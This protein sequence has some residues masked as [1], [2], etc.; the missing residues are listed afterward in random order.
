MARRL[1]LSLILICIVSFGGLALIFAA[2]AHP[3]LGLDL[4]GGISVTLEPKAGTQ[5]DRAG[6]DLA[7][8]RIRER[9]DSL[10]VAEPEILRQG[11]AIVINLPGVENQDK[12]LQLVQVTGKVNL[13]PVLRCSAPTVTPDSTTGS[14]TESTTVGETT[15]PGSSTPA[16]TVRDSATTVPAAATTATSVPASAGFR[17][18][19]GTG[20]TT[21]PPTTDAATDS[22]DTPPTTAVGAPEESTVPTDSTGP[23]EAPTTTVAIS[24]PNV[25]Q[26]LP[27]RDGGG[28]LVGASGG[29]GEVFESDA[30]ASI[31]PGSGWGVTVTLKSGA[32]GEGVWN[33]L[34][35]QCNGGAQTCPSGQLAIELDGDIIS[36][37][38]MNQSS[39]TGGVQIS[40]SFAESEAKNLA[41]VLRS[42]ALPVELTTQTVQNV[43]PT[44]GSDSLRAAI[45]SGLVGVALVLLFMILY[46][47][48]LGVVVVAGVVVSG[49][50]I[51]SVISL[52]S[53]TSGL[54]LS[55]SGITGI[56]ISV[57]V[58][59]DS[60]VVFFERLKDE[61]R[62]GRTMK[63]GAQRG[64][65]GAW[66][67]I[68]V[69]DL[70]SLIGAVVLWYL[71][72]G[73]VRNFAF[74]LGLSTLCDL[75]VAYYFTRPAVLLLART[76]FMARRK[77]MG[78]E[79]TNTPTPAGAA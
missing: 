14:T 7:V 16:N 65:A 58:T 32:N 61:V 39:Y 25:S 45:V 1:W 71:T 41:R 76:Q 33:Q 77:V 5:Y 35:A 63:N 64:F 51:W 78:I 36:H 74:F 59:V 79:A 60:Y 46:Y 30:Q 8:D 56:I 21:V 17:R 49:A 31:L 37:P 19:A 42:G 28:C 6:L 12:A 4:K 26:Y 22:T 20:T 29:T 53:K 40:G 15:L 50:L 3:A 34:A 72:V 18:A 66:H 27:A 68:L 48:L 38:T 75:G 13:R 62:A 2:D 23:G 11:D 57:G 43:S 47:R 54:A 70:V 69:A 9:V 10:G 24:D 55:L 73:S 67:T 44:L 52:L